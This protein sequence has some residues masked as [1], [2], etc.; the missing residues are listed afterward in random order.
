MIVLQGARKPVE[1]VGFSPD[2]RGLVSLCAGIVQVWADITASRPP[3]DACRCFARS[4]RFTPDGRKL[5]LGVGAVDLALH[6]FATGE[7]AEV[8]SA[9]LIPAFCELTPDG[10]AAVVAEMLNLGNLVVSGRLTCRL[11]DDWTSPCWSADIERRPYAPPLFPPGGDRFVLFEGLPDVVPFCYAIRDARTGHLLDEVLSSGRQYHSPVQL[12]DR[13]LVAART[14]IWA[15]VFRAEDFSAGP[16]VELRND[17]RKEFTGLAFHPSGRYLAAT[18]N[19]ATVKLYDTATWKMVQAFHWEVG[20][21]RS[22]AFSPDGMVA[23]AGGDKG[24]IVL[25]DVDL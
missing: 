19:D 23:A 18:S 15:A 3:I 12:V 24:K 25:W 7:L 16:V 2:G 1:T 21:L 22:I 5:L 6:D 10:R 8:A 13:T 20:R 11:L 14:G 17:N 9:F 4:A